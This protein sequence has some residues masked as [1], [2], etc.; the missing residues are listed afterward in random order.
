MAQKKEKII[1]TGLMGNAT[2]YSVK[3]LS[4]A[5]RLTGFMI[6]FLIA[7]LVTY[8]FFRTA[9]VSFAAGI[10]AGLISVRIY[11]NYLR[12]KRKNNLLLQFKD[13]MES[14][15]SS[16]SAGKNTYEAFRDSVADMKNIYGDDADIVKEVETI[17]FGLQ[18]NYKIESL[19]LDFAVRSGLEDIRSFAD[20]F[21]V[22]NRQ[23]G[24]IN[25]VVRESRAMISEKIEVEQ[26]I[27]TQLNGGKNE[28]NILIAMP[29]VIVM[30]MSADSS[31]SI[32]S[33]TPVNVI[34]KC[35]CLMIFVSAYVLGRRIINIKV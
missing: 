11:R 5:E 18:N 15:T 27:R 9:A 3:K 24:D 35:V 4:A 28:L 29:L 12:E 13:L 34:I 31:M 25:R 16:Y 20:V 30:M 10:T 33:N 26:E 2:D 22:C 6:G 17:M 14:L 23:G 7:A 1:K 8:I 19:M 32:A 21:E